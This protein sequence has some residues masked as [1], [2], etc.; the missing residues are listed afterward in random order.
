MGEGV[1][2]G[3]FA[4][5]DGVGE[6]EV[7]AEDLLDGGLEGDWVGGVPCRF[8]EL[9]DGEGGEGFGGGGGGVDSCGGCGG[10]GLGA[11]EAIAMGV[12]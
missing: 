5:E 1:F 6:D 4:F 8:D 10:R 12:C 11:R 2:D 7:G 3:D 9:E